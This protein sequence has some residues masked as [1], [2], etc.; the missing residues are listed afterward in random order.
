MPPHDNV[1]TTPITSR[2]PIAIINITV[3]LC[4]SSTGG[5]SEF[6]QKLDRATSPQPWPRT[7]RHNPG[8]SAPSSAT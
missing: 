8:T 4:P 1:T 3:T 5:D 2:T 6:S 7:P